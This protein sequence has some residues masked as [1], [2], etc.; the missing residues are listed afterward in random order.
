MV[1]RTKIPGLRNRSLRYLF[2]LFVLS[3]SVGLVK[4]N[5]ACS[6]KN[7]FVL[8]GEGNVNRLMDH[9]IILKNKFVLQA[10]ILIEMP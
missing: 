10:K 5:V 4:C 6:I 7:N 8:Y 1:S 2:Y 9:V 3:R